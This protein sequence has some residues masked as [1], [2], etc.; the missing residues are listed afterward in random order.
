MHTTTPVSADPVDLLV[1]T[2]GDTDHPT[3]RTPDS[4][5]AYLLAITGGGWCAPRVPTFTADELT[6]SEP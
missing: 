5:R 6:L 3:L 4:V 1:A 2:H